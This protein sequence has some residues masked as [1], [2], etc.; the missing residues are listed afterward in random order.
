MDAQNLDPAGSIFN[1]PST[2]GTNQYL[3]PKVEPGKT[4][5]GVPEEV[6]KEEEE[7]FDP[8]EVVQVNAKPTPEVTTKGNPKPK[9]GKCKF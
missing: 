5:R 4:F 1:K 2:S 6:L 8:T 3:P 7:T 9:K